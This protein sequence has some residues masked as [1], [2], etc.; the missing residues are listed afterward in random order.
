MRMALL[1]ILTLAL[2]SCAKK[3]DAAESSNSPEASAAAIVSAFYRQLA[4]T[5]VS[6]APDAAQLK[7]IALYLSQELQT[8]LRQARELHDKEATAAPTEK[9]AFA[10]G[11]LFSSLF[12]GPTAFEVESET[13]N[14]DSTWVK[15]R[16]HYDKSAEKT[17][18]TDNV[19]VTL[20]N[21]RYVI[22]DIEYQ[23]SWEFS[24]QDSLLSLLKR[25]HAPAPAGTPTTP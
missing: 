21:N 10:D 25:S 6:G 3:P 19:L 22:S 17:E 24:N 20:E 15:V 16:F 9:P 8:E 18:W 23:G 4:T 11:D 1:L 13:R 2:T 5:T 14:G 7:A 12:E